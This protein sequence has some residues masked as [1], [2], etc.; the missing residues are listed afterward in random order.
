MSKKCIDSGE[1]IILTE[2]Q[3]KRD[4]EML[5]QVKRYQEERDMYDSDRCLNEA[6]DGL[7]GRLIGFNIVNRSKN[8][9][10]CKNSNGELLEVKAIN[11]CSKEWSPIFNDTT[12][13]KALEFKNENVYVQVPIFLNAKDISFFLIGNNPDVGDFL[14]TAARNFK[15]STSR[16]C[17]PKIEVTQLYSKYNFKIVAVDESK[18]QVVERLKN[19]YKKAFKDITA[20]DIMTVDEYNKWKENNKIK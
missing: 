11:F 20:D 15:K 5:N 14:L 12:E 2:E 19:K 16:R 6:K 4:E 10:D 9:F 7:A 17:S 18:E 1:F 3:I 13:S 8:G